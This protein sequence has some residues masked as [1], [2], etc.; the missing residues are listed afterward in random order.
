MDVPPLTPPFLQK[1]EGIELIT[2]LVDVPPTSLPLARALSSQ[3]AQDLLVG[4]LHTPCNELKIALLILIRTIVDTCTRNN[5]PLHSTQ[6][7]VHAIPT[8]LSL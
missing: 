8:Y 7:R 4:L 2:V 5:I 3:D 6:V 1:L